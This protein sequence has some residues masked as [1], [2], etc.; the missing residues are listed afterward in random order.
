MNGNRGVQ[1]ALR[2]DEEAVDKAEGPG[3]RTRRLGIFHQC[4]YRF[5]Q[6]YERCLCRQ[7]RREEV[8]P[9]LQEERTGLRCVL[10][11]LATDV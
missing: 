10:F 2:E 8:L 1:E 5:S 11:R 3:H 6:L 9:K 7:A 4:L